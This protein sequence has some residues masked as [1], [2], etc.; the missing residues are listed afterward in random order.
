MRPVNFQSVGGEESNQQALG[1]LERAAKRA[2]FKE[3]SFLCEPLAAGGLIMKPH[4]S[5]T[6]SIGCRYRRGY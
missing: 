4:Y 1:I 5:K 2:G 3:V 6:K